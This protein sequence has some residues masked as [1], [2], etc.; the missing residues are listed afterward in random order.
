M[1]DKKTPPVD[2]KNPATL[3]AMLGAKALEEFRREE[4]D[5]PFLVKLDDP[6]TNTG[7]AIKYAG[8]AVLVTASVVAGNEISRKIHK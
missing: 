5:R 3:A 7:V 1:S 4:D 6:V 2:M 8:I